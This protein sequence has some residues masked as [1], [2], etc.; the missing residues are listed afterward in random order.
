M[1]DTVL[2]AEAALNVEIIT[3]IPNVETRV[4][5]P[6]HVVVVAIPNKRG[7]NK[8]TISLFHLFRKRLLFAPMSYKSYRHVSSTDNS[9]RV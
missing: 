3:E 4:E 1:K 7:E 5:I 2:Y 6:P 8:R 9:D